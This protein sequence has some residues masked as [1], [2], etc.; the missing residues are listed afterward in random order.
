MSIDSLINQGVYPIGD[1]EAAW[2]SPKTIVV[3]GPPRSGTSIVAGTLNKLGIFTGDAAKSPTFED[4]RLATAV[5]GQSDESASNIVEDY[6]SRHDIWAYKRPAIVH[7]LKE[8]QELFRNPFYVFI[9][10]DIFS[11]GNRNRI[12]MGV[13]LIQNMDSVQRQYRKVLNFLR[14]GSPNGMLVSQGNIMQDKASFVDS[15]ISVLPEGSVDEERRNAALQFIDPNPEEYLEQSRNSKGSGH[16]D[17]LTRST[18]SGRAVYPAAPESRPTIEVSVDGTP[19]MSVEC[20]ADK[21]DGYFR[22]EGQFEQML[23]EGQKVSAR[24]SRD[25]RTFDEATLPRG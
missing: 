22:F 5:E 8:T 24:L 17:S 19:S 11:I 25:I 6:N 14:D 13:D 23:A 1:S 9:F 20:E 18:I 7:S 4:L 12:S 21:T 15:M 3:V 16:I 2:Q 10:K